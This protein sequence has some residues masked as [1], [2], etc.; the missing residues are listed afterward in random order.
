MRN[1]NRFFVKRNRKS[2]VTK[3]RRMNYTEDWNTIC[4]EVKQRDEY[5]CK[6]CGGTEE[7]EVH[8]IIPLSRGGTNKKTNLITL[9]IKHHKARHKHLH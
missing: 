3:I 6:I 5:K 7:L 9:C 2:G 8:H 4:R 1:S